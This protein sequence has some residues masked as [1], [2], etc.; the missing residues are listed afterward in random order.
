MVLPVSEGWLAAAKNA[1][2]VK[3]RKCEM[4]VEKLGRPNH[5]KIKATLVRS[6]YV[7]TAVLP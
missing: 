7:A 1:A 4:M 5:R 6:A 2:R 3:P